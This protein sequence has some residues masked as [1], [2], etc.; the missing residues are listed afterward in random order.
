M[1]NCELQE[2]VVNI[3]LEHFPLKSHSG[4]VLDY[5]ADAKRFLLQAD[6]YFKN[7]P[8]SRVFK[9]DVAGKGY[10][11]GVELTFRRG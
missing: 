11:D 10:R 2:K 7:N 3:L 8:R 9:L 6:N 4:S 1:L 5:Y